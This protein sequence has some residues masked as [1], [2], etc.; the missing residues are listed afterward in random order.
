MDTLKYYF[1]AMAVHIKG[2]SQY[3]G[4]FFLQILSTV[5]LTGWEFAAIFVL[6]ARFPSMGQWRREDIIFFYGLM[7]VA[8][9][10]AE[11]I[12]RGF[13]AFSGD[14]RSGGFDR[15]LLR[16]RT[17]FI[18]V[19][20]NQLD[21]RR[22]GALLVGISALIL[23]A[24]VAGITWTATKLLCLALALLGGV[25]LLFAL[26]MIEAIACL[27][28]IA[29]IEI[30]NVF[31]YGGRTACQYPI[32]IYRSGFRWLFLYV[33]P[34]GLVMHLPASYILGKTILNF[35]PWL[36]FFSPL[37]GF[38]FFGIC[39]LLWNVSVK[40]YHSTGS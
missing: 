20:C 9:A 18:S 6:F 40:G 16:P 8:F 14:V 23:G 24:N 31:T 2:Q 15:M 28:T 27:K 30:V 32:D 21:L 19:L 37:F 5:F 29:S 17:T 36:A 26:F 34:Y 38:L 22:L 39:L 12:A 7:N 25:A 1:H 3:K 13:N 11:L 33:V 35:P 10:V 4:S